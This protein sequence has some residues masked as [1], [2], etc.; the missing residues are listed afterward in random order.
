MPQRGA[1][2]G[3]LVLAALLF[4]AGCEADTPAED[5]S[6]CVARNECY[7]GQLYRCAPPDGAV[8]KSE[9]V[10]ICCRT[11]EQRCPYGCAAQGA[12]LDAPLADL[13]EA[14][15]L[16]GTR[17]RMDF[18]RTGGFFTAPFPSQELQDPKTGH[19]DLS[20]FPN[21]SKNAYAAQLLEIIERDTD[22]FALTGGVFFSLSDAPDTSAFPLAPTATGEAPFFLVEVPL[23]R[24]VP[25]AGVPVPL[26]ADYH[27]DGGPY[28][29]PHL[30][31][32]LPLQGVPLNPGSRYAAVVRR[33]L[34]DAEGDDLAVSPS[35]A[36][37]AAGEAPE[38]LTEPALTDYRE[39][40]RTV[41]FALLDADEIAAIAVFR[42]GRPTEELATFRDAALAQP[43][44]TPTAPPEL[45]ELLDDFCVFRTT[46]E[47]PVYQSG[48]PPF[49]SAGGAWAVSEESGDPEIQA[50]E[51]ARVVV[52]VPR[53]PMPA[54]GYPIVHLI[55]TGAGG[56]RPLVDR[57]PADA[58]HTDA[59]E[60]GTGPALHFARA[61]WAGISVD[62]PHGGLRNITQG[63]EQFLIFNITNPLA[64]RDNIRQ[65]ALEA[66]L[67]AHVLADWTFA[68]EG[69]DGAADTVRFDPGNI[70]LMGHSMGATIAPLALQREPLYRATILSG[71]G[72]SWI[73]NI[74]WKRS[75]I[76]VRPMAEVIV[77]YAL[78]G[79]SL[80]RHD[81][82]LTL[83]QWAG[84][85]ADPP[86]YARL[87]TNGTT[88][89]SPLHVLML[90]GIVDTYI[91]PPIANAT[92]LS[93]GLDL[94]RPP[95]DD[96][97]CGETPFLALAELLPLVGRH[98]TSLPVRANRGD[99]TA[100]VVQHPEDGIQD[101][102]EVVFQ[103]PAP[104]Y[105]YRCFLETLAQGAPTVFPFAGAD[106]PCPTARSGA[107]RGSPESP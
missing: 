63:D 19:V 81:P 47:M 36:A 95:L 11:L 62:G 89:V 65:S 104:Q 49:A 9:P 107:G 67:V 23:D 38:G 32:L 18:S 3:W 28:G 12:P 44:P 8:P 77:G 2:F 35:L 78:Q 58:P 69:C 100:V 98:T 55:R 20:A 105:Q 15:P 64:M 52:T 101:G 73:E 83:L 71:A 41:T 31:S 54:D 51:E 59:R 86:V 97:C 74:V 48:D 82:V 76:E 34:G 39:A 21:P 29:A 99:A 13:C 96:P 57:G 79:R 43:L 22:G 85:A 103:T 45:V 24:Y 106:E 68:S 6:W 27:A 1:K 92:S 93:F 80:H 72:G 4:V 75:P 56:D 5:W 87:A 37:L 30:L 84:E 10:R 33:S 46:V 90:Q 70:A 42:T 94:A 17:I 61:G 50:W 40:L 66:I 7:L 88:R 25:A 16:E 60:P 102:H 14:P 53:R 91:L 26:R